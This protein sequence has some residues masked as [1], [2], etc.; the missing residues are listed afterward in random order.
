MKKFLLEGLAALPLAGIFAYLGQ[1]ELPVIILALALIVD[2]ATGLV[3]AW[4]L[5]SI[6]SRTAF[7]GVLKKLAS[8]VAVFVGA[9]IDFLLPVILESIGISYSPRLIFWLLVVLWLCVNEFVSVLENL[10]A[11]GVPF[12]GFLRKIT[13]ALK[14]KVEQDGEAALGVYKTKEKNQ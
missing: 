7:A 13:D 4:T 5:K 10:Q 6:S 9:E 11:I 1:M 14:Q 3:K 8:F 12:P 2:L